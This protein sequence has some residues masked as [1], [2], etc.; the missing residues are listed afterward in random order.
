MSLRLNGFT[1]VLTNKSF[2][3][4]RIEALIGES[5]PS[6]MKIASCCQGYKSSDKKGSDKL[7][8]Y[9]FFL[10]NYIEE[11]HYTNHRKFFNCDSNFPRSL[12]GLFLLKQ[13]LDFEYVD[14]Q[15]LSDRKMLEGAVEQSKSGRA[16]LTSREGGRRYNM[17]L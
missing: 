11:K 2:R 6:N 17:S 3:T 9:P 12:K 14:T 4:A 1:E 5:V 8:P 10:E 15:P 13:T 7:P 16:R